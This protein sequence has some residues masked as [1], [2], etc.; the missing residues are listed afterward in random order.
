MPSPQ[1]NIQIINVSAEV[2]P[3][4]ATN[5]LGHWT[6]DGDEVATIIDNGDNTAR[7]V[8]KGDDIVGKVFINWTANDLSGVQAMIPFEFVNNAIGL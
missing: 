6:L 1:S 8:P 4:D 3:A 2:S 7:I 5:K